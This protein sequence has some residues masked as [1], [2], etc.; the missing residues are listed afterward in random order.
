SSSANL[1]WVIER[2]Q[3]KNVAT[4]YCLDSGGNTSSGKVP[5]YLYRDCSSSSTNL[6]WI[7]ERGQIKNR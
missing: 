7:I 2:G 4:G 3:I 5:A 6:T 1:R